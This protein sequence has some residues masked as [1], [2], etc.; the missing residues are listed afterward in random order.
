MVSRAT[1][2]DLAWS[3]AFVTLGSAGSA[4]AYRDSIRSFSAWHLHDR[5]GHL[6]CFS[7][8]NATIDSVAGKNHRLK[9]GH[10]ILWLPSLIQ[11]HGVIAIPGYAAH[12]LQ[13]FTTVAGI[14]LFPG[15]RWAAIG[16]RKAGLRSA[17]ATGFVTVNLAGAIGVLSAGLL[18][19]EVASLGCGVARQIRRRSRDRRSTGSRT[20]AEMF[21][22]AERALE[23]IARDRG[24]TEQ[25]NR[26]FRSE[27]DGRSPA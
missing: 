19:Y 16:L 23:R 2:I 5:P 15:A 6:R 18:A 4:L 27:E 3:S 13:D 21:A 14:P 8:V 17:V 26:S 11:K 24:T 12:V 9:Y 10:T 25:T 1:G 22:N 7:A 20:V